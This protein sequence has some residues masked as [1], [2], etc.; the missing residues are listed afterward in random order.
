MTKK[1]T[2]T[3]GTTAAAADLPPRR[4]DCPPD[5]DE[6]GRSTWTLLHTMAAQYPE[7]PTRGQQADAAGFV[8]A[9]ANLY[10]CWSCAGD[11][12][13]WMGGAGGAPRVGSRED[14]GRWLCEAHNAVNV[15]LGKPVFD[16][17]RWLERW[18]TGWKNGSCD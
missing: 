7:R 8:G 10:P 3:A 13:E 11:F 12:R 15:K 1:Q 6:L 17:G 16:C 4:A 2:S 14:F 18:R 5:V 9:L